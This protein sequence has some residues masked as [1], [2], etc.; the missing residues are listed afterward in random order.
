[1]KYYGLGKRNIVLIEDNRYFIILTKRYWE[2]AKVVKAIDWKNV[3]DDIKLLELE[4]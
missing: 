1:M 4:E 3:K 2:I